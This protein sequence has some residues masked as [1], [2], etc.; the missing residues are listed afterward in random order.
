MISDDQKKQLDRQ[1][2][3]PEFRKIIERNLETPEN[4]KR[5]PM[6]QH[7]DPIGVDENGKPF[8]LTKQPK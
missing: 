1:N 3:S 6:E 2:I 4:E 5:E 8:P 7:R